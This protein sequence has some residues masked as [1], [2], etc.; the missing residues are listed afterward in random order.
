MRSDEV[1]RVRGRKE[2]LQSDNLEQEAEGPVSFNDL[3]EEEVQEVVELSINSM[4]GLSA[5]KTMKV[6]GNI[7][8]QEVIVLS[9]CGAT[10][11]FISTQLVQRLR[12]P[13]EATSTYGVLM[14]TSRAVK[15]EGI[16]R[17]VVITLHNIKI[18]ED[19][20]P[21]DLGSANVILGM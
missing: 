1:G 7:A 8:R 16:C 18:V 6:K 10:H 5:P 12:L 11:N 13:L 14:G 4:V 17:V 15:G 3:Q 21:L 9:D 20:L 2:Y 19:F